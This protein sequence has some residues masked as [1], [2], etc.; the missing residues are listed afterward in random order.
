MWTLLFYVK[1]DQDRFEYNYAIS[2]VV[3]PLFEA[4]EKLTSTLRDVV[5]QCKRKYEVYE[6]I[7][8]S[9]E[10]A[11]H[12]VEAGRYW[13]GSRRYRLSNTTMAAEVTARP[14][15]PAD[16]VGS[17]GSPEAIADFI[18]Y[19]L[20]DDKESSACLVLW[21]HGGAFRVPF[22]SLLR[23]MSAGP[24]EASGKLGMLASSDEILAEG[25]DD[26]TADG[27]V[28]NADRFHTLPQLERGLREGLGKVGRRKFEVLAF[29]SCF[30]ACAEAAYQLRDLAEVM[31]GS[32]ESTPFE[33]WDHKEWTGQLAEHPGWTADEIAAC[34][35][36]SFGRRNTPGTTLSAIRMGRTMEH[37]AGRVSD[38]VD[39]ALKSDEWAGLQEARAETA[40][41]G[42]Y[43]DDLDV[44]MVDIATLFQRI[45]A[46]CPGLAIAA[47]KVEQAC[48]GAMACPA[49]AHPSRRGRYGSTGLSIFFPDSLKNFT[50]LAMNERYDPSSLD[51]P[52]FVKASR[53]REFLDKY[54]EKST[55][56]V[57]PA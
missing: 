29:N 23:P 57:V 46:H 49:Y 47:G 16:A 32:E 13:K 5:V 25:R 38:F 40:Q 17:M 51:A 30:M 11:E 12:W 26:H 6:K 56:E 9:Q 53:W 48:L 20:K 1:A 50:R 3:L 44:L 36:S 27:R 42:Y 21:G 54:W 41:Y 2:Q 24:L 39:L 8:W 55:Q 19:S 28:G 22:L 34:M 52:D 45:Q 35:V 31:V 15:E 18:E 37:V 4:R 43:R 33:Q 7:E 14:P 10:Q